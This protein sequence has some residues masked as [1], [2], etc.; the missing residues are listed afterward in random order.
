M[1]IGACPSS[2]WGMS[3]DPRVDLAPGGE[4]LA[5]RMGYP[6]EYAEGIDMEFQDFTVRGLN[7]QRIL[8]VRQAEWVASTMVVNHFNKFARQSPKQWSNDHEKLTTTN[9]REHWTPPIFHKQ[10]HLP[11]GQLKGCS[12]GALLRSNPSAFQAL[13]ASSDVDTWRHQRRTENHRKPG[14]ITCAAGHSS[15]FL[16]L[17][18]RF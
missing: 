5:S 15:K 4:T 3:R 17:K 13:A 16:G 10:N 14:G 2:S 12:S 18:A 8:P 11:L 7:F 6:W 1:M 9:G